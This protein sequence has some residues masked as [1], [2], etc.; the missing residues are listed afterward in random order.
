MNEAISL[1]W[2]CGPAIYG[3]T[4]NLRTKKENGYQTCPFDKMITNYKG[5]IQCIKDDFKFFCDPDYLK[6]ITVKDQYYHLNFPVNSTII[7]NTKYKFILNHESSG[8]ADLWKKEKW[9]KGQFHF[10]QDN[11]FEFIQR[12]KRRIE[13]FQNY[14]NGNYEIKFIISKINN[15]PENNVELENIIKE[16]YPNL[17]FTLILLEEERVEIFNEGIYFTSTIQDSDIV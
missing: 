8:H 5:M 12:Y 11:F 10:E 7:V 9:A 6:V 2:D 3:V 17:K 14:L 13:N 15:T 16:K 1:G 4:N